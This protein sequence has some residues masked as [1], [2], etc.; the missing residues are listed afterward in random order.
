MF[1]GGSVEEFMFLR[2]QTQENETARA[3]KEAE[4]K[5][6]RQREQIEIERK[7]AQESFKGWLEDLV[8]NQL[9]RALDKPGN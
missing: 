2:R 1:T 5:A 8:N 4:E 6:A 3:V 9:P 7:A